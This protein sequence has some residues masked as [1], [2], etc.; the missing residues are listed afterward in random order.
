MNVKLPIFPGGEPAQF[1]W[2]FGG[3]IA[4][5]AGLFAFFKHREWL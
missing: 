1:W 2:I 3:M 5:T 4:I